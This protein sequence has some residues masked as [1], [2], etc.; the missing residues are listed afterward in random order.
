MTFFRIFI[1]GKSSIIN[2]NLVRMI[3]LDR[4]SIEIIWGLSH[5][6]GNMFWFTTSTRK[7]VLRFD[8]ANEA[9]AIYSEIVSKV[10]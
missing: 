9:N 8:T 1:A 2:L 5:L 10:T 4:N 7:E 6:D 3:S